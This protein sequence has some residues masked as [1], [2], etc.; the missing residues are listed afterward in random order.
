MW[1]P[2]NILNTGGVSVERLQGDSELFKYI[3]DCLMHHTRLPPSN[4]PPFRGYIGNSIWLRSSTR[5]GTTNRLRS[6]ARSGTTKRLRSS[7][8]SG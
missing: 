6:S 2:A 7:A 8:R 5:S 1:R 4:L 3:F